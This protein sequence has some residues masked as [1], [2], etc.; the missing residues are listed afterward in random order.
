MKHLF[1]TLVFILFLNEVVAQ[2]WG[3]YEY[4]DTDV[5]DFSIEEMK[6]KTAEGTSFHWSDKATLPLPTF[7]EMTHG[8]KIPFEGIGYDSFQNKLIFTAITNGKKFPIYK[9]I[10]E[11]RLN[12]DTISKLGKYLISIEN[13]DGRKLKGLLLEISPDFKNISFASGA[14]KKLFKNNDNE[15]GKIEFARKTFELPISSLSQ[16]T[17]S[18]LRKIHDNRFKSLFQIAARII[19][20]KIKYFK[21]QEQ[22]NPVDEQAENQKVIENSKLIDER[23]QEIFEIKQRNEKL[24]L[25]WQEKHEIWEKE[26]KDFSEKI[27]HV[28]NWARNDERAWKAV[29]EETGKRASTSVYSNLIAKDVE[30]EPLFTKAQ[31]GLSIIGAISKNIRGK[32]EHYKRISLG[33][34]I[35]TQPYQWDGHISRDSCELYSSYYTRPSYAFSIFDTEAKREPKKPQIENLPREIPKYNAKRPWREFQKLEEDNLNEIEGI[36][37]D[38]DNFIKNQ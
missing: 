27:E 25:P 8:R 9:N 38:W 5:V 29:M 4:Y 3:T 33:Y 11:L 16:D 6:W 21:E 12:K 15:L 14:E 35:N 37:S 13:K 31:K 32:K 24:L 18:I 1:G 28:T 2:N 7:L 26:V 34:T 30:S 20:A 22:N 10:D 19:E 17:Q 36:I 23:N